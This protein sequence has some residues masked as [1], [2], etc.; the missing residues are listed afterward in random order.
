ML[1]GLIAVLVGVVFLPVL[2]NGFILFDDPT[3][4]TANGFV[5]QG[6]SLRTL[7]WAFHTF[8]ATNWHPLAWISHLADVSLFGLDPRG[9][10]L[11]SLL[12]H[13]GNAALVFLVLQR[14]TGARLP[15]A[16]T[17]ALFGLHPAHVE[18]VAWVA[19]RKDVLAAFFWLLAL[20]AY[21]GFARRRS[22]GRY[23]AL[24]ALFALSLLAKPMA[25]SLPFVLLLLD[26]WP[27]GRFERRPSDGKRARTWLAPVVEKIPLF[28]LAIA[29]GVVTVMAQS[30]L[31]DLSSRPSNAIVS[32]V[33]YLGT[34]VWPVD[35]A[36]FY[37]LPPG[38]IPL[39][40]AAAS[41]VLLVAITAVS[42]VLARRQPV[43]AMGWFWYL[44]TIAPVI[45]VVQV[46]LQARADRYLYLPS[47]GLLFLFGWTARAVVRKRWAAFVAALFVVVLAMLAAA[48]RQQ[49]AYW[50]DNRTLFGRAL[51]VTSGNWMALHLLSQEEAAAGQPEEAFRLE[52]AALRINPTYGD[53]WNHLGTLLA[54]AGRLTEATTAYREAVQHSPGLAIPRYN[55]AF[56]YLREGNLEAAIAELEVLRR[57]DPELAEG[58]SKF[59][60]VPMPA[61]SGSGFSAPTP[62]PGQ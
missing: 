11:T 62:G 33:R 28:A 12:L 13:A 21:V 24:L 23:A 39:E 44:I 6:L 32:G 57:L 20:A 40:M 22:P 10:H 59:F 19:E 16:I 27:L 1:A 29:D 58:L 43:L 35:L 37:P 18:S 55:L 50:H 5:R 38:G 42:V 14:L 56:R 51:A 52:Q 15:A 30:S 46:G 49:I 31:G 36:A 45:G 8:H 17:G 34:L 47:I 53:G 7:T 3:Y 48:T 61:G 4:V 60:G 25:I 26:Y 54:A 2:D 41:L 9:H